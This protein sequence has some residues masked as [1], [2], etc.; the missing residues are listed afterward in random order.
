MDMKNNGAAEWVTLKEASI[1]TGK[2]PS[3][4]LMW[5][6]RRRERG[7]HFGIKKEKGRHG[8]NWMIHSSLIELLERKS[9]LTGGSIS[10]GASAST[11][12][13]SS[14]DGVNMVSKSGIEREDTAELRSEREYSQNMA[15]TINNNPSD[16]SSRASEV[17]SCERPGGREEEN[18]ALVSLIPFE[19]YEQKRKEWEKELE[20]KRR[21]WQEERDDLRAG[22]LMYRYKYEDLDKKVK[23]LP[24]FILEED[25]VEKAKQLI[26]K[27][28]DKLVEKKMGQQWL[29]RF[30]LIVVIIISITMV[31]LSY[32]QIIKERNISQSRIDMMMRKPEQDRK[33]IT[34]SDMKAE[35]GIN[36]F[37]SGKSGYEK[38]LE[39][40]GK[41]S[42]NFKKPEYIQKKSSKAA[43]GKNTSKNGNKKAFPANR[44]SW[45]IM[46]RCVFF[47]AR[48]VKPSYQGKALLCFFKSEEKTVIDLKTILLENNFELISIYRIPQKEAVN[49]VQ[50]RYYKDKDKK[51]AD[52]IAAIVKEKT[53]KYSKPLKF[54]DSKRK[55]SNLNVEVRL[56]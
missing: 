18:P 47:S 53:G 4:L 1:I 16:V 35:N 9:Q 11:L 17:S 50:I 24:P 20:E 8:S 40:G 56:P 22:L 37:I 36:N 54:S 33:L 21:E 42:V 34:D 2:K 23:L 25:G 26:D 48:K 32:L 39:S 14:G 52:R 28:L 31:S 41:E 3:A 30:S 45:A 15:F 12:G 51:I 7:D 46:K 13:T 49:A 19:V 29:K 43:G 5:I 55:I 10:P 6:R 27:D 44:S 38:T